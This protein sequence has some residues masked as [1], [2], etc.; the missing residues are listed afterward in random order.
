MIH[1]SDKT[2][3]QIYIPVVNWIRKL[4]VSLEAFKHILLMVT[5]YDSNDRYCR[6]V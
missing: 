6:R 2:Q 3:G 4:Q 5:S 1:T